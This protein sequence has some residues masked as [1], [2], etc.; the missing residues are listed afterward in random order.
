M[1]TYNLKITIP[2]RLDKLIASPLV[3][4]RWLWYGYTFRRV[5]LNLG[6]YARVDPSW[7]HEISK[8]TWFAKKD[9]HYATTYKAVRLTP[10]GSFNCLIYMHRQILNAPKGRIV[11]H[12]DGNGLNNTVDNLRFATHSQNAS[13]RPKFKSKTS[14][15]YIG[16][17]FKKDSSRWIA[18]ITLKGKRF[19]LGRFDSEIEAAKAYDYAAKKYHREFACLN[20]PE[21]KAKGLRGLL[22]HGFTPVFAKQ[23][24]RRGGQIN[25]IYKK[26]T[27]D[28]AD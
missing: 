28:C 8:Y 1:P 16:V 23:Q 12:K 21:R 20:F 19:W 11:D 3:L 9:S 22:R 10:H 7:F 4:C 24:L 27:A 5:P 6:L 13:N 2:Q 15:R 18:Y 17:S 25:T 26:L 14:S